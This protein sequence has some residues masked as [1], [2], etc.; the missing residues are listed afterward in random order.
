MIQWQPMSSCPEDRDVLLWMHDGLTQFVV[1]ARYRE[2][3]PTLWDQN[4]FGFD[5]NARAWAE[6]LPPDFLGENARRKQ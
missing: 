2:D 3:T 6:C 1:F 4:D 5:N